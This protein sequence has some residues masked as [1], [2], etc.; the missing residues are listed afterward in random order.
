VGTIV[1]AAERLKGEK[2]VAFV[3]I[4]EG[5]QKAV[6]ERWA[7]ERGLRNLFLVGAFPRAMARKL[8]EQM[9]VCLVALPAGEHF[10]AT[11]TSKMFDYMAA[12]KPVLFCGAGDSADVIAESGCGFTA[13]S[14]D[15]EGM[16]S[17]LL[18][19]KNDPALKR[20]MGRAAREWFEKNI[21]T[22]SAVEIMR[23]T[24]G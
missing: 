18:R 17:L 8:I 1:R 21:G 22:E 14:H 6:Y 23:K 4:G 7:R 24:L 13:P 19:V 11:L 20:S 2:G 3:I 10:H 9:D 15:D 16:G 12:K 5:E